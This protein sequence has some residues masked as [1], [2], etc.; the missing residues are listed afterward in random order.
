MSVGSGLRGVW[1]LVKLWLGSEFQG[2]R[3]FPRHG[4]QGCAM[5][6]LTK[7]SLT[8]KARLNAG[9]L[10]PSRDPRAEEAG[11]DQSWTGKKR[12]T[13]AQDICA[14]AL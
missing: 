8:R 7:T 5:E 6:A 3:A 11:L 13:R 1:V 10:P 12:T 9:L 2:Q 14:A 4:Q